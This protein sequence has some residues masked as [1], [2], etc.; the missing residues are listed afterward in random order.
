[1]NF[2]DMQWHMTL[3][4]EEAEAAYRADEVPVGAVIVSAEGVVIA[5]AH[6]LKEHSKDPCDHA[7][8]AAIR[9]AATELG[10]WRLTGATLIVTL[11]PCPMCLAAMVQARIECLVFGAYD[12]KGGS[13]SLGYHLHNDTRLNH[14]FKVVGGVHHFESARLLSQFFR[15]KRQGYKLKKP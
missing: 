8:I 3:A 14:R 7:E 1:M 5:R 15:Q 4:L 2:T 6:N 10:Q 13:L 9:K 12:P 11:E